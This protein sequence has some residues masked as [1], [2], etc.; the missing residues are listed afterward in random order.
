MKYKIITK[1]LLA[2]SKKAF[3]ANIGR[4][5]SVLYMLHA[6]FGTIFRI[7]GSWNKFLEEAYEKDF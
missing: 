5:S 7:T 2:Y 4:F 6:A 3:F 1:I